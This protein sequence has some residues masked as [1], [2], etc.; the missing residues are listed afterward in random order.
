MKKKN[1]TVGATIDLI[2][3]DFQV[4][5]KLGEVVVAANFGDDSEGD[6]SVAHLG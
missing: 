5:V 4:G 2:G 1:A 3:F 6:V